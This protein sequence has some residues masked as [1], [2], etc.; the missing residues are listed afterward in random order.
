MLLSTPAR[1]SHCLLCAKIHPSTS[2][3]SYL[4]TEQQTLLLS[5]S[6]QMHNPKAKSQIQKPTQPP[7]QADNGT[8]TVQRTKTAPRTSDCC[9]SGF[10]LLS[11]VFCLASTTYGSPA[12]QSRGSF[13]L[14]YRP[15][16]NIRSACTEAT[17]TP[18]FGL[19]TPPAVAVRD[20]VK[21]P[22]RA[23]AAFCFFFR[24]PSRR[25]LVAALSRVF[26]PGQHRVPTISP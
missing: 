13:I 2:Y 24:L 11:S 8:C 3:N 1:G 15:T 14:P 21:L 7:N 10:W 5:P 9:S 19:E 6:K 26:C 25:A 4:G 23:A 20:Q 16:P 18:T 17:V 12:S 22:R